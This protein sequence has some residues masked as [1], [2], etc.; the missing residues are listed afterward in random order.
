MT[1]VLWTLIVCSIGVVLCFLGYVYV[2][3]LSNSK[4]YV[5]IKGEDLVKLHEQQK[6]KN[7]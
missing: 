5:V 4:N 6:S 3:G 2:L 7:P 1:W